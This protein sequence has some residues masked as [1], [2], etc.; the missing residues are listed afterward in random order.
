MERSFWEARWQE[1][2]TGFHRQDVHPQLRGN[3]DAWVRPLRQDAA[4]GAGG[5][6]S[7]LRLLVPLCGKSMDM[8]WL[9]QLGASVVGIEFVEQAAREFFDSLAV[10]PQVTAHPWGKRFSRSSD[11]KQPGT[12]DVEIWVTDFFA[13]KANDLGPV[14]AVY[15]RAA[16]VAVPPERRSAYVQQLQRLMQPAARVLLISFEHDGGDGPPF[17]LPPSDV[18]GLLNQ[19]FDAALVADEDILP[20][21]P[22]FR[23]RGMTVLREQVWLATR[24]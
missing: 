22:R 7:G 23:D 5:N 16:L 12:G 19:E 3:A 13:L 6:F 2:R 24:R 14:H 17:S 11:D 10:V 4:L 1:Q 21:E 18:Q 9:A 15:D 8:V 20:N